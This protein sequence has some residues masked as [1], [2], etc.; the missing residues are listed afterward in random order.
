[1]S[2]RD[3][4]RERSDAVSYKKPTECSLLFRLHGL[5]SLQR[6]R[7]VFGNDLVLHEILRRC[8]DAQSMVNL[9]LALLGHWSPNGGLLF[10]QAYA[11]ITTP[12]ILYIGESDQLFGSHND[13][14]VAQRKPHRSHRVEST[15]LALNVSSDAPPLPAS[16]DLGPGA[17]AERPDA[18]SHGD[19]SAGALAACRVK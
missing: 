9:G 14:D 19:R 17:G 15:L 3:D 2:Q 10:L 12:T 16:A 1:M 7:S 13:R 6:V 11:R 5:S 4:S 8:G 18:E